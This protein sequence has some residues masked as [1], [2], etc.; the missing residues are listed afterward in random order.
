MTF[1]HWN[2]SL[3]HQKISN[4]YPL[5]TVS[6]PMCGILE[7]ILLLFFFLLLVVLSENICLTIPPLGKISLCTQFY[8][9]SEQKDIPAKSLEIKA[10]DNIGRQA[11]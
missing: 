1:F 5:T 8:I 3:L 7:E 9:K 6:L 10:Q 4:T 11:R 2:I